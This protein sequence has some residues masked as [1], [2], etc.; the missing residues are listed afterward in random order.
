MPLRIDTAELYD[1][2]EFLGE[3]LKR[4]G[5]PREDF[6]IIT[7]LSLPESRRENA[8]ATLTSQLVK[9][10]TTYVDLY[11]LH[12]LSEGDPDWKPTLKV[13]QH[14]VDRGWVRT[15]A[16]AH[17]PAA[18]GALYAAQVVHS[19]YSDECGSG[20]T[21]NS[22][23]ISTTSLTGWPETV[24]PIR[25]PIVRAIAKHYGLSPA[26]VLLRWAMEHGPVS[27]YP[28]FIR[29]TSLV[30]RACFG[31]ITPRLIKSCA[32]FAPS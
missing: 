11:H 30:L 12:H 25:D 18:H 17:N 15:L 13:L 6:F 20:L 3:V 28:T 4:S 16:G 19:I 31:S 27:F 9:L 8:L 22:L 23:R 2:E 1:N 5:I 21:K 10:Q 26:Q 29:P 14:A 7:K 32:G 24:L